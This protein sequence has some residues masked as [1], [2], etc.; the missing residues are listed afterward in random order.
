MGAVNVDSG[1]LLK[2]LQD[3]RTAISSIESTKSSINKKYQQLGS[4]WKDKKYK[5]LGDIVTR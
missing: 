2:V 5:E 3:I 1:E 4:D